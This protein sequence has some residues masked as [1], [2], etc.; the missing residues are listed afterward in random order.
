[1]S[2]SQKLKIYR[3]PS[4]RRGAVAKAFDCNRDDYGFRYP[5]EKINYNLLIFTFL[6]YGN[7]KS[8]ALSSASQQEIPRKFS[9]KWGTKCLNIRF[10]LL[11]LLPCCVRD[12]E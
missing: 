2:H 6:H 10:P 3:Q 12:R 1:M 11:L 5:F 8:T 9:E 4:I 7:S